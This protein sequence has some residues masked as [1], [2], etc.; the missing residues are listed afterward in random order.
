VEVLF[1]AF[2]NRVYQHSVN[3][4]GEQAHRLSPP[5]TAQDHPDSGLSHVDD[6]TES[7]EVSAMSTDIES[8]NANPAKKH[9]PVRRRLGQAALALAMALGIVAV[10]GTPAFAASST[11]TIWWTGPGSCTT[12]NV[13]PYPSGTWVDWKVSGG[14]F[15]STSWRMVDSSNGVTVGS[16]NVPAGKTYSGTVFGLYNQNGYYIRIS[17]SWAGYATVEN[18]LP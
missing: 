1:G 18:N 2:T 11:C 15:G 16:G 4:S 3:A 9:S 7:E 8:M 12:G 6:S 14:A 17:S 13:P 10:T 5:P